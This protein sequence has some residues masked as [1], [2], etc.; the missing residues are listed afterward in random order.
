M[1][2]EQA[3]ARIEEIERVLVPALNDERVALQRQLDGIIV[4]RVADVTEKELTDKYNEIKAAYAAKEAEPV[5]AR[6]AT[7]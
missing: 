3:K 5:A 7:K 6:S 1:T 4:A 2:N